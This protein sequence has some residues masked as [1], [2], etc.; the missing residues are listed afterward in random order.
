MKV[1]IISTIYNKEKFLRNH[2]DSLLE[3][4]YSDIEYIFV[5]DGSTDHSLSIL[6]EYQEKY[7]EIHV[8]DQKNTGS[9]FARKADLK[10]SCGDLIYFVDSD[11]MLY[12]KNSIS[13][14]VD[15]F[16]KHEEIDMVISALVNSYDNR[17]ELDKVIYNEAL[18]PGVYDV[19]YLYDHV[20]RF[21]LYCK[22]IKR[23]FIK[24]EDFV[25]VKN[26]EDCYFSYNVFDRIQKFYYDEVPIY[27]VN[28]KQSNNERIT[29]TLKIEQIREKYE[30]YQRISEEHSSFSPA[31]EKIRL[32]NYFDDLDYALLLNCR[33]KAELLKFTKS[34]FDKKYLKKE[35]LLSKHY[36]KI[37]EY[38]W[39]YENMVFNCLLGNLKKAKYKIG[40]IF[41]NMKNMKEERI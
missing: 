2:I 25:K 39:I 17:D 29:A 33:D 32:K 38:R 41:K 9:S 14:I 22:V 10:A 19:T 6:E 26:H 24:E 30:I 15:I 4:D 12:Q 3:Q 35:N 5:N 11:D 23:E 1:S 18:K 34:Q 7:P 16:E 21:A 8:V 20:V 37:Y 27:V 31:L 36:R 13:R 40:R 28:Q